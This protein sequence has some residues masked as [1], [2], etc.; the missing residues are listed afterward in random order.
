MTESNRQKEER[1]FIASAK[2]LWPDM[3]VQP[4]TI[5]RFLAWEEKRG[6]ELCDLRAI[7][8]AAKPAPEPEPPVQTGNPE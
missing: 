7:E 5:V 4:R 8:G 2:V 6:R 3:T 1:A